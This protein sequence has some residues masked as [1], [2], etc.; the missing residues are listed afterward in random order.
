MI[1]KIKL[2]K[3]LTEVVG[4]RVYSMRER[5]SGKMPGE[6][7]ISKWREE[8]IGCLNLPPYVIQF[9]HFKTEV[10]QFTAMIME[11]VEDANE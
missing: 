5:M 2:R 1:N 7:D 8:Y 11:A 10:D 9:N 4:V 6:Y 3:A